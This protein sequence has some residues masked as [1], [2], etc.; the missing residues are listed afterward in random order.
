[1]T[2]EQYTTRQKK[3]QHLTRE[4]RAQIEVLL[5]QG[6]TKAQIAHVV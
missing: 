1:M 6:V 5:Q 3:F 4:K 2:Q